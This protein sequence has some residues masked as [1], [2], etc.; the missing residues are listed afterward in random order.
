MLTYSCG[1]GT[2]CLMSACLTPSHNL[3]TFALLNYVRFKECV[4]L[5]EYMDRMGMNRPFA[6]EYV[7]IS[8]QT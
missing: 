5:T 7:E 2:Y 3:D 6:R 8:I 1:K 4:Q